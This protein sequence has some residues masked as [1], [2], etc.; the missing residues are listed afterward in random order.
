MLISLIHVYEI[1]RPLEAS[2][3]RECDAGQICCFQPHSWE[4]QVASKLVLKQY[5][6]SITVYL[7]KIAHL[8]FT[9]DIY[10]YLLTKRAVRGGG[11]VRREERASLKAQAI[12]YHVNKTT[13]WTQYHASNWKRISQLLLADWDTVFWGRIS[14]LKIMELQLRIQK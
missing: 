6:S 5:C 2:V 7:P 9:S 3:G 12:M 1:R 10:F 8:C 14:M 13:E 4:E 11:A